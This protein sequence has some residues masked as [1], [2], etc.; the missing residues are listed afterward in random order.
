MKRQ[1]KLLRVST[2]FDIAVDTSKE[3]E[4]FDYADIEKEYNN[5]GDDKDF[6][7]EI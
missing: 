2:V 4:L 7:I 1:K 5:C 3:D 6:G